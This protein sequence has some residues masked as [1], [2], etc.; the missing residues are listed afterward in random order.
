VCVFLANEC[1]VSN[2]AI[3]ELRRLQAAFAPRGVTFWYLHPNADETDAAVRR[4]AKEYALPGIPL[5]D[6]GLKLAHLTGAK[7]TP[8][9]VVLSPAGEVLYRGRIDDLYAALGQARPEPTRH[10]LEL[11]LTAVL[12]GRKPEPAETR[13][14]GCRLVETP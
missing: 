10:D 1:P 11:A 12:S 7:V 6:P 13:A 14:V 5:R 2:R 9:A 4:H 8:T 3:P